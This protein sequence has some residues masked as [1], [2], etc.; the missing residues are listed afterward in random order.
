MTVKGFHSK[1]LCSFM[2]MDHALKRQLKAIIKTYETVNKQF[3]IT[4]NSVGI[5]KNNETIIYN[6]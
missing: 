2:E 3:L 6:I 4:I 5:F 1:S